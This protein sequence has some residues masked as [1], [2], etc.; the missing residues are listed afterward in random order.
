MGFYKESIGNT[1]QFWK[2][3]LGG[4]LLY[5]LFFIPLY[6]IGYVCIIITGLVFSSSGH[7]MIPL[8]IVGGLIILLVGMIQGGGYPLLVRQVEKDKKIS[9]IKA[10]KESFTK[11]H[12]IIAVSFIAAIPTLILAASLS[13][14]AYLYISNIFHGPEIFDTTFYNS[15]RTDILDYQTMGI[16]GA[17]AATTNS[18]FSIILLII[19]IISLPFAIY[20]PVKLFFSLPIL[21]IEKKGVMESLKMSWNVTKGVFWVILAISLTIAVI[22]GFIQGIIGVI[23]FIGNILESVINYLFIAPLTG[24]LT[25]I[26]YYTMKYRKSKE[27]K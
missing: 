10:F 16:S 8:M 14:L 6:L 1:F 20:I 5:Q 2:K 17:I 12:K 22:T 4:L 7:I 19:S 9:I 26:C 18:T 21:M 23:P 15:N 3:Y 25:T 11:L 27:E 13:G 24:I